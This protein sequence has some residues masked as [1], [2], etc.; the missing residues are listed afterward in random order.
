MGW[1]SNARKIERLM[2][3]DAQYIHGQWSFCSMLHF[4]FTVLSDAA[5]TTRGERDVPP[6]E[7]LLCHLR[8]VFSGLGFTDCHHLQEERLELPL[9]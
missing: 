3:C 9:G 7:R 4:T 1:I 8:D 5:V 6:A 2:Q